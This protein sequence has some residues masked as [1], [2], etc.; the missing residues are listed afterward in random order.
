MHHVVCNYCSVYLFLKYHVHCNVSIAAKYY[1]QE[2]PRG[3]NDMNNLYKHHIRFHFFQGRGIYST[4]CPTISGDLKTSVNRGFRLLTIACW[5]SRE[6]KMSLQCVS[7]F[8]FES[9]RIGGTV[10]E[11]RAMYVPVSIDYMKGEP[12]PVVSSLAI[13]VPCIWPRHACQAIQVSWKSQYRE[14]RMYNIHPRPWS[15]HIGFPSQISILRS[16]NS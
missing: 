7:H 13:P 9:N 1:Y 12:S 5:Q 4:C 8:H 14:K 16:W 2:E 11:W 15:A 6:N 3:Y 10:V